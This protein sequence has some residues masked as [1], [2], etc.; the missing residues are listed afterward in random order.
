MHVTGEENLNQE[1]QIKHSCVSRHLAC[2]R[3]AREAGA[4]GQTEQAGEALR[5]AAR[6]TVGATGAHRSCW[7]A[8]PLWVN[9][10]Q[11]RTVTLWDLNLNKITLPAV[12]KFQ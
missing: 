6:T 8:K 10:N 1:K 9:G 2:S 5:D 11:W 4:V 7:I 3:A 12:Y